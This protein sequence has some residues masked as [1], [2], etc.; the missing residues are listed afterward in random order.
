MWYTSENNCQNI[1]LIFLYLILIHTYVFK[2]NFSSPRDDPNTVIWL[3]QY[4][5]D[6]DRH[7]EQQVPWQHICSPT[8]NIQNNIYDIIICSCAR[9]L[10]LC[11]DYLAYPHWLNVAITLV[12]QLTRYNPGFYRFVA[13]AVYIVREQMSPNVQKFMIFN[14]FSTPNYSVLKIKYAENVLFR[15]ISFLQVEWHWTVRTVGCSMNYLI[16]G[17]F[18][19]CKR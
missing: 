17:D 16:S 2:Q 14:N 9:Y 15:R 10:L 12:I 11:W 7:G 3:C 5:R 13:P 1:H 6:S 8:P 18:T 4:Y 19:V